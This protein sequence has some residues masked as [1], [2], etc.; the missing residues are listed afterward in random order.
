MGALPRLNLRA[1]SEDTAPV[2][3]DAPSVFWTPMTPHPMETE[4]RVYRVWAAAP[5]RER[6]GAVSVAIA[7]PLDAVRGRMMRLRGVED[8]KV[9]P[10]C[11]QPA[12]QIKQSG[13]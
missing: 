13:S 7:V 2:V 12:L 6:C 1:G 5:R 10:R 3:S 8:K 11:R 9:K 4:W